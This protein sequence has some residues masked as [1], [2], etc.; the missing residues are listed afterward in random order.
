MR[1]FEV[2]ASGPTVFCPPDRRQAKENHAVVV[3]DR[4]ER[5]A[6]AADKHETRR[7]DN[8]AVGRRQHQGLAE[9]DAATPV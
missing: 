3:I 6:I 9:D 5:L 1:F 7:W 2:W 4:P 8:R